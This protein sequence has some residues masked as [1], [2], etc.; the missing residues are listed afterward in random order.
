MVLPNLGHQ[1]RRRFWLRV[2]IPATGALVVVFLLTGAVESLTAVPSVWSCYAA[3]VAGPRLLGIPAGQGFL[4]MSEHGVSYGDRQVVPW[5]AVTGVAWR[6]RR[7]RARAFFTHTGWKP[8]GLSRWFG[9]KLALP[10]S[11]FDPHW[12]DNQEARRVLRAY[13]PA[14]DV[15]D[16][17][18]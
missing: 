9:S 1:R 18:S 11:F 3:F 12:L 16:P 8:S 17:P 5:S 2:C 4:A 6:G 13:A 14:L 15:A 10:I 7:G